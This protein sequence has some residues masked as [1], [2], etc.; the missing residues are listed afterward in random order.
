[1]TTHKTESTVLMISRDGLCPRFRIFGNWPYFVRSVTMLVSGKVA[2]DRV[3][4]VGAA[5]CY[6]LGI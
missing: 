6:G 3:S 4:S 1:M 2:M 5:I